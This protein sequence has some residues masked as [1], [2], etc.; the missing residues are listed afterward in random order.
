MSESNCITKTNVISSQM[1]RNGTY[2]A[3]SGVTSNPNFIYGVKIKIIESILND[4]VSVTITEKD[5]EL[6]KDTLVNYFKEKNNETLN[7]SP[8]W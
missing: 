3:V 8:E 4:E 5:A 6:L 7:D 1:V 2:C